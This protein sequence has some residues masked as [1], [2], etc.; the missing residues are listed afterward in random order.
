MRVMKSVRSIDKERDG[1]L[2]D[3]ARC[4]KCNSELEMGGRS[5]RRVV[6]E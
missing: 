1:I 5:S 6:D 2:A 3:V 4:E